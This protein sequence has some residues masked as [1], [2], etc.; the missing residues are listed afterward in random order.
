MQPCEIDGSVGLSARR[1]GIIEHRQVTSG[2]QLVDPT[3]SA[4]G[5]V[6]VL[7]L[8]FHVLSCEHLFSPDDIVKDIGV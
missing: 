5:V 2:E 4:R 3:N 8:W 7:V 1:S 6:I